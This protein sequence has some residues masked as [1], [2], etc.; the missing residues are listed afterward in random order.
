MPVMDEFKNERESI[1]NASLSKKLEYFKDYY[2]LKT[3]AVIAVA[4]FSG[5]FLFHVFSAKETALYAVLVNFTELQENTDGLTAPFAEK[6]LNPKKQSV[7][8][9][10]SSF[11]SSDENEVNFVKYGYEDEQRLF[12]M[13]MAGDMDLFISGE[14]IISHYAEQTW[15]DD[16]STV[17]SES[18]LQ[19][20][21]ER[22]LYH[23]GIPVAVRIPESSVLNQYYYYSGNSTEGI[24]AGFPA[25]SSRRTTAVNFLMYLFE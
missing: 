23:Q 2:L 5:S 22:I 18:D 11:I 3:I 21:N 14:D 4:L 20:L 24:Y 16:L 25:G 15:F 10:H 8:I 12:T 1:R 17:L 9:D 19:K 6:Y 13:V 7:I